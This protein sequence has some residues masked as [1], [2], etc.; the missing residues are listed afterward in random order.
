MVIGT[1][2]TLILLAGVL[3][4]GCA[5]P[6]RPLYHWGEYQPSVYEHF[7]AET[8]P[9]E[10]ILKLEESVQSAAAAGEA[11][12]PGYHAHLG[13]LYGR[14]GRSEEMRRAL[15]A[16]KAQFPESAIFMD[17]LLAKFK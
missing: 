4:S 15:E 11:L 10:Q 6:P 16:E 13:L 3:L 12:P 7:R 17:R 14:V 8:S 1:R 5:T 9:E 2:L